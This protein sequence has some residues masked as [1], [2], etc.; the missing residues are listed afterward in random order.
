MSADSPSGKVHRKAGGETLWRLSENLRRLRK[1]RGYT[2][3]EL[4]RICGFSTSY[5][6]NV[7][8]GRVNITLAN[9]EAL[10]KGLSCWEE[11]LL[12]PPPL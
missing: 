3:R 1:A 11:D 9:L 12:R 7:E 2:Q 8:Q 5:I 4:A 10:A 6:G